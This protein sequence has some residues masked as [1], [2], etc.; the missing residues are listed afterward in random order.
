MIIAKWFSN[1]KADKPQLGYVMISRCKTRY[2]LLVMEP[3]KYE[4]CIY[5]KPTEECLNE[6]QRLNGLSLNTIK[7]F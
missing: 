3:L 6:N 7:K 2:N 1:N 4:D 5:F